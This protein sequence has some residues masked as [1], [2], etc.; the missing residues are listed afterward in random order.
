MKNLIVY[1]S[2]SGT[3]KRAASKLA[4][5]VNGTL[6]E[7]VPKQIYSAEDLDWTDKSSRSSIEIKNL[8]LRPEIEDITMDINLF[9]TI[10]VGFPIWWGKEPKIILTLL[11]DYNLEG[12]T[13]IPFC[14][15]GSSGIETSV[16]NL[17]KYNDKLN[18][19]DGKRFSKNTSKDE[20]KSWIESYK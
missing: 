9:D 19:L 6:Y 4:E 12:K 5:E 3:T 1:F 10:Y 8:N 14:T 2:A 11:D 16:G 20:I 18:V 7:I 13:I 15:S 17:R